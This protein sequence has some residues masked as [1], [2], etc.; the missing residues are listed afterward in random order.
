MAERGRKGEGNNWNKRRGGKK[1]E[2]M[3]MKLL[4]SCQMEAGSVCQVKRYENYESGTIW[5]CSFA[6]TICVSVKQ[7]QQNVGRW[8]DVDGLST[9]RVPTFLSRMGLSKV[10]KP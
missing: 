4:L 6:S 5:S 3:L 1:T 2:M 8:A 7:P 9:I 10:P